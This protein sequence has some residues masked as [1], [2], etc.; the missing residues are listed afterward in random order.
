LNVNI[1]ILGICMMMVI[2]LLDTSMLIMII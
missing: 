1:S 2:W